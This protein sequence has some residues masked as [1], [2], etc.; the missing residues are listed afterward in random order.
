MGILVYSLL[1]VMKDYIINGSWG[2]MG[3]FSGF[4]GLGS[5]VNP[6]LDPKPNTLQP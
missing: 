4:K 6:A 5:E 2:G 3:W 1:W